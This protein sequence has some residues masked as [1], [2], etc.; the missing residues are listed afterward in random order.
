MKKIYLLLIVVSI[1]VSAFAQKNIIKTSPL[2]LLYGRYNLQYERLLSE[3][4]SASASVSYLQPSLFGLEKMFSEFV[5]YDILEDTRM[6]G[7][8][9]FLDYRA[10]PMNKTGAHGFYIAPYMRYSSLGFRTNVNLSGMNLSSEEEQSL[11]NIKTGFSI[12]RIGYGLKIGMHWVVKD[13]IS[14]DWNFAGVGADLY[15]FKTFDYYKEYGVYKEK[16]TDENI[17]RL[18]YAMNFAIGYAF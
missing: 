5:G 18:S 4:T 17:W 8:S 11:N 12:D 2:G 7:V 13:V 3:H 1:T 10:Y 16:I 9:I 15:N 6:K 14:I